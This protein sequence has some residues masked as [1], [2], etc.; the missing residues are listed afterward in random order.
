M[1]L[2]FFGIACMAIIFSCKN[3][4]GSSS[5][6]G[7]EDFPSEMVTFSPI[8][9]NP[10]FKAGAPGAWDQTIRERGYILYEDSVYKLWYTGFTSHADTDTKK[11]GYAT[12]KDGIHWDRYPGNPVYDNYWTEDVFVFRHNQKYYMY[13]EGVKDVAHHLE[14][15]DGINWKE[16]GSLTII[17]VNGDTLQGPYGTPVVWVENDKWYLFYET[18]DAGIWL[19]TSTDKKVWRNVFDEAVIKP[20]PEKFDLGAVAANQVFKYK[21]KYYLHYHANAD[22]MW[23]SRPAPWSSNVAVSDDLMHWR[24]YPGNP[25]IEGDHS[26]A[27]TVFDGKK[28]RL[29]A[30]HPEVWM[31]EGEAL[32]D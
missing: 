32:K 16:L 17:K 28:I 9:N 19:A 20:G 30:M 21:N 4:P 2:M 27:I 10:V 22:P 25:I 3:K 15:D 31:Y 24:K 26:S 13:A 14:S 6:A 7:A 12:S 11:L 1:K 23:D 18:L 29:Y 5:I 8:A